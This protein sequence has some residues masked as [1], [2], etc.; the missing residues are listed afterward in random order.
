MTAAGCASRSSPAVAPTAADLAIVTWNMHGGRGDLPQLVSDLSS[1][2]LTG[3]PLSSY[4]L[5]LQEATIAGEQGVDTLAR[6]R[7][8]SAFFSP[9]RVG[10]SRSIGNAIV[11][12][13][14][15]LNARSIV[16]PQVRQPRAA[17][18]A[19]IETEGRRLFIASVHLENRVSWLRVGLFAEGGRAR[20]AEALLRALPANEDGIIG[21][22]LNTWLGDR[23]PLWQ[24]LLERFDDTPRERSEPTFRGRLILDHLFFDLPEG[25]SVTR[26]VVADR[27]NSDHHPVLG[28]ITGGEP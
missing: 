15:L 17:V 14:Q 5:L 2:R 11:S 10:E 20:Q 24:T 9:V 21:G 27:Y 4:V 28:L 3:T 12:T 7:N 22:D 19:A 8:L 13:R 23:E 26:R 25:W 18:A 6:T 16:L 1:G